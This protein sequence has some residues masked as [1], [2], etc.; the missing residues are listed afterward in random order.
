S[1]FR[2]TTRLGW[3][4]PQYKWFVMEQFRKTTAQ[5]TYDDAVRLSRQ[6]QQMEGETDD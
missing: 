5:V 6:F 3:S 4:L 2:E 1:V